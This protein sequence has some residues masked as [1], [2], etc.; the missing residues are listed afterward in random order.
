MCNSAVNLIKTRII[1]QPDPKLHS[2]SNNIAPEMSS[3][4]NVPLL[5]K[6]G[7]KFSWI[8]PSGRGRVVRAQLWWPK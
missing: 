4:Q 3:W 7:S 5:I 1:D 6:E 8:A 2:G